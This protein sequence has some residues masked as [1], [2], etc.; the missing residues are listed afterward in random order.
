MS[1]MLLEKKDFET[2]LHELQE[3]KRLLHGSQKK[4]ALNEYINTDEAAK[5]LKVTTRTLQNWRDQRSISFIQIGSK[6]LFKKTDVEDFLMGHH[7]KR[8]EG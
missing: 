2:L 7:I 6:I 5:L 4:Q 8:K 3:I 1:Y